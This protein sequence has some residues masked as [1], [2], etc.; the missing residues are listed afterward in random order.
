MEKNFKIIAGL[1]V[2]LVIGFFLAK[3]YFEHRGCEEPMY[4][5]STPIPA[6][7]AVKEMQS[8]VSPSHY[9]TYMIDYNT[10]DSSIKTVKAIPS[11]SSFS[12][13]VASGGGFQLNSTPTPANISIDA[14]TVNFKA[15]KANSIG[16]FLDSIYGDD[17]NGN[18][19]AFR[20]ND[21]VRIK[22]GASDG[23]VVFGVA[24]LE[25]TSLG[26]AAGAQTTTK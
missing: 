26:L 16:F 9:G 5:V 25:N 7:A 14:N 2:G 4:L 18:R 15:L 21:I 24:N 10:S 23:S 17:A 12:I 1:L 6:T 22:R 11:S 13:T 8:T 20:V 3:F 19:V